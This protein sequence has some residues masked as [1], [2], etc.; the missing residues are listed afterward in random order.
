MT[1]GT[2]FDIKR[3]AINDGPGIRTAVFFK[4]CPLRC[5]WCHN[6]EG[7]ELQPQ[8]MFRANRCRGFRDCLQAC[9]HGAISWVDG[10]ITNWEACDG[11]GKCAEVCVAGGREIVGRV[12][13]VQDLM[14]EIERDMV[15]YNQ[16]GG[17]VTFTGGEP[18]LQREFLRAMLACCKTMGIHT[19]VD[20]SGY[21]TWEGLESIYPL[22]DL[23]LYDLKLV[24]ETRHRQYTSVSNKLILENLQKLSAIKANIL[25]R[26]PLIPGINDDDENIHSSARFL[27]CLP[28]LA[29]VELMPY[30]EIGLAKYQ[31]LGKKYQLED[32]RPAKGE[33]IE[34]VERILAEYNLPV[35]KH[36]S[37]RTL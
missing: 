4:G 29:G 21:A 24:D 16:S 9:P 11:C 12:V 15:F 7:Q 20:T 19:T 30:H 6:P 18:L 33:K 37:G 17:G 31:A 13:Q 1:S 25:V 35:I 14:T 32:I 22:T 3:Y 34:G 27:K 26:I 2:I 5:S 28:Y 8:L 36:S 23:F 10:S